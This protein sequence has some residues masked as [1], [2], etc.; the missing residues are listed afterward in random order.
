MFKSEVDAPYTPTSF[1]GHSSVSPTPPTPA[2]LTGV[3]AEVM[4]LRPLIADAT[5]VIREYL[6]NCMRDLA[7]Q[8]GGTTLELV[9][10]AYDDVPEAGGSGGA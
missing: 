2:N 5:G 9:G 6:V 3:V 10:D 1:T 8:L 4:R 7:R